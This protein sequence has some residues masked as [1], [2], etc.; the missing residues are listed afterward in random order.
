MRLR[1][2]HVLVLVALGGASVAASAV[3][4]TGDSSITA[5]AGPV[6]AFP[7]PGTE[8]AQRGTEISLRGV[9]ADAVGSVT[10]TGSRS[11]ERS[12]TL[13]P[14]PDGRGASFVPAGNFRPGERV[15]VRTD[16]D[17]R[18]GSDGDYRFTIARGDFERPT[19]SS[20]RRVPRPRSGSYHAYRSTSLRTPRLN[21]RTRRSGR[22]PGLLVLNTGWDDARPRPEGILLADD[23]GQPVYFKG[24]EARTKV[25]DVAVQE[26]QG[27]P[28]LTYWQGVFAAGWGYGE[29]VMLDENYREV[30]RVR[31]LSGYRADIHDMQITP[32]GTALVM[33]YNAVRRDLRP[34][35]GPRNGIVLDNVIQEIDLESRRLLF[36]WHSLG[37]I[38]LAESRDRPERGMPF[39]YFH[40]NG[41]DVAPDGDLLLS[42]RNTCAVYEVDRTTGAVN[43]RLGGKRSD[44]R[45]NKAARFCRQHDA[46]WYREGELSIFDNHVDR[47]RDGGESRAIKLA[48]DERR[49]RARLLRGYKHPG[50]L[51]AQNKGGTRVQPNGNVLVAWGAVP[52]ITEYTRT[53]RIVFDARFARAND[54]SYRVQRAP[55][56]GR[57][58]TEP[59]VAAQRRGGR[60]AVWASWNGATEV[61]RWEVLAGDSAES[62]APVG[63]RA[64]SGFE[65]AISVDGRHAFV[66]VRAL[67]RSGAVLGTSRTVT[68]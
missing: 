66:A 25:F 59:D 14:H 38:A 19:Q 27:R 68:P 64:R 24:R 10:V 43:W 60:T 29:Y 57:P 34:V 67:D 63:G 53:G 54:G 40:L 22:A 58:L 26:Y 4:L 41:V 32:E 18:G 23:R 50:E 30:Q 42:A 61:A 47:L 56:V 28:V 33:S 11:G 5:Q 2:A 44:F 7:A 49:K 3:A 21:V 13:E 45:M 46:R 6:S 36:E 65:T 62:L 37:N 1:R 48:V 8:T 12:G 35:G 16:L 20:D 31:A 52:V 51:V 17:V 39:D 55:W 9:A 15:T